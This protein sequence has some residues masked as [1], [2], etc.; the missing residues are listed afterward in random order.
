MIAISNLQAPERFH[1]RVETNLTVKV[2]AQ[3]RAYPAMAK[4]LS[5]AGLYLMGDYGDVDRIT[6]AIPLPRDKEIVSVCQVKR[7]HPDG[8]GL[9][10]EGLDWEDL[11]ALAR[12]MHPRLP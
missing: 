12:F 10:F 11:F 3:G 5:M 6:V 9:E 4:D 2:L 1:P 7:R 8:V